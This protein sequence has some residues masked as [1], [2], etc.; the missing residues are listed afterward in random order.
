M[1]KQRGKLRANEDIMVPK[2]KSLEIQRYMVLAPKDVLFL[3]SLYEN[4]SIYEIQKE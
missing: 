3:N 4:P 2:S 1:Y